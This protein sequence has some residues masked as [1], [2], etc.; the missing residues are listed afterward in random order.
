M[1]KWL[2]A[3]AVAAVGLTS[4]ANAAIIV[5]LVAT[6]NP[7]QG[8]AGT[9]AG[10]TGY[11]VQLQNTTGQPITGVDINNNGGGF[12]G[13]LAQRWTIAADPDTGDPVTT[14]TPRGT[15]RGADSTNSANL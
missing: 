7:P 5:N 6:N 3:S 2:L 14:K 1:K 15:A 13:P 11:V 10:Y 4:A 8:S 9:L 12:A